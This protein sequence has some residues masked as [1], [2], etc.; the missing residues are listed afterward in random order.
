MDA[1]LAN[2]V[3]VGVGARDAHVGVLDPRFFGFDDIDDFRLPT[4]A[5][6]EAEDHAH[7]HL[8]PVGRVGAAGSRL[9]RHDRVAGVVRARKERLQF[10]RLE[11]LDQ[12]VAHRPGF[13]R[14]IRVL[15]FVGQLGQRLR[16]VHAL[17]QAVE[18][19]ARG[20]GVLQLADALVRDFR[21]VPEV[22]LAHLMF[23]FTPQR[24][25]AVVVKESP[26]AARCPHGSC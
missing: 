15:H 18:R 22:A 10:E 24:T 3:A 11:A 9:E 13:L 7:E 5:F 8:R 20:T 16:V 6:G 17:L 19:F 25:F 26:E 2:E 12:L 14:G 23:D 4:H 21:V 1:H